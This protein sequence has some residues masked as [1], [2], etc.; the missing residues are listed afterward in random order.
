M[1][2]SAAALVAM[3][4]CTRKSA[5]SEAHL[6][7]DGGKEP[8][9][10]ELLDFDWCFRPVPAPDPKGAVALER[11]VW[12][13]E[14]SGATPDKMSSPDLDTSGSEWKRVDTSTPQ[15]DYAGYAWFRTVLPELEWPGRTVAFRHVDDNA[16]VYLNGKLLDSHKGWDSPFTVYVDPAWR[17][18]GPNVLVVRVENIGGPGGIYGDVSLRRLAVSELFF[19]PDCDETAWRKVQL[20]HDYIVEGQYSFQAD[21][22][23]GSLPVYPAW[24]RKRFSL[25]AA[26]QGKCV[27][28]YFEGVFR[29]AHIY[30]NGTLVGRHADGYT[31]FHLDISDAVHFGKDNLLAVSVDPTAFEGWWYEGGGIYRHVW[32]N[33]A[34]KTHVSP[35]G[36]YVMSE[37]TR[38][39]DSPSAKLRI[40]TTVAN[41]TGETQTCSVVSTVLDPAG[42]V[43]GVATDRLLAP[44]TPIPADARDKILLS[45]DVDQPSYLHTGTPLTQEL[46]ISSVRLWSLEECNLYTLVT[47]ISRNGKVVDRHTQRFGIRTLRFDPEAGFF[48]NGEPVKLNGVCNHQ[49]FAGVGIGL[50]Y[51]LLYYRLNKLKEFGCNAI[52]CSHNPM[53]PAMYAACDELGLLVMDENRHP[54]SAVS[55]KSWVGQPYSNSWHVESMVLRDRNHPSVIMWTMWNEEFGIQNTPFEREMMAALR[56]AV[57]KH[58]FPEGGHH[59]TFKG[60]I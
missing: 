39:T 50:T 41:R 55:A 28:L 10:C 7:A 22:S 5:Q 31:S 19:R 32:L 16:E 21:T 58:G 53:A 8:R 23:H 34:D 12:T 20:P 11:W 1:G 46:T 36:V 57:H 17:V 14:N 54:G 45:P 48:L 40:V 47:E 56:E 60:H 38:V 52:R 24:Y 18:G 37:V 4:S 6:P 3:P 35:W 30:V 59:F 49:D 26:D 29:D 2:L 44:S 15:M 33:V 43:A 9:R 42:R 27:W 13:R 51:S 25:E